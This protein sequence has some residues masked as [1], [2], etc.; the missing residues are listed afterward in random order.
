MVKKEFMSTILVT[1][2]DHTMTRS[3][4]LCISSASKH[5]CDRFYAHNPD[6]IAQEFKTLNAE[7]F[8]QPRGAGC[9]WLFKPYII[10]KAMIQPST[11]EG[12][13]IVYSDAGVE[14][15]NSVRHIIDRM[16]EDIF[17]FTNT[18]KQVEWTKGII[19]DTILPEWR[20]GRYDDRMQVQASNIFIRVNDRT[21]KFFK[22]YLTYCQLPGLIDDSESPT[23]N[24]P[25][26]AENRHDQSILCALQI[27]YGYKLHWFPTETA[28]HIHHHTPDD[29]YPVLF[30]HHR[31]RNH[32]WT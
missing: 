29:N 8:S 16:D 4:E 19:M 5:G 10:Y 12:D 6:T 26:F 18:F 3:K 24:Y 25:T 20:D 17:F 30:R 7:I 2:A 1:Y 22:E 14:F 9:Y 27:K 28:H 21:K 11:N 23:P 13:I 32:E 31:L 15:V